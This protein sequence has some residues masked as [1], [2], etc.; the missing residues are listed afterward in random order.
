MVTFEN[1]G[2]KQNVS[3]IECERMHVKKDLA[4]IKP[5]PIIKQSIFTKYIYNIYFIFLAVYLWENKNLRMA[6][7]ILPFVWIVRLPK[8]PNYSDV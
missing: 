2:L 3:K 7:K 6:V 1:G 5:S 4:K 8:T